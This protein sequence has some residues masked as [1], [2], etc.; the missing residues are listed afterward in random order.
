MIGF[1]VVPTI[2]EATQET[3]T[4]IPE[5]TLTDAQ[6]E[7]VTTRFGDFI[8]GIDGDADPVPLELS[9]QELNALLREFGSAFSDFPVDSIVLTIQDD[10]LKADASVPTDV[11]PFLSFIAPGRYLNGA[12]VVS[13][14]LSDGELEINLEDIQF[15]ALPIPAEAIQEMQQ[16]NLGR[17]IMNN[18]EIRAY[19]RKLES[20]EVTDGKLI[21]T[22]KVPDS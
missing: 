13:V 19:I 9:G 16:E 5:I 21:I 15:G 12:S 8:A 11:V 17:E 3:P 18:P 10:V 22:P 4:E 14:S 7:D 1:V 20:V 6:Q 2:R